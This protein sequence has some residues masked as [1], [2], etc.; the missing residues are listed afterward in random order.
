VVSGQ[1]VL[2]RR[3]GVH[4]DDYDLILHFTSYFGRA[5]ADQHIDFTAHAEFRQI[6]PRL[7]GKSSYSA[8]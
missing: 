5:P 4:S 8:G 7:D 6:D 1:R 2:S 3:S